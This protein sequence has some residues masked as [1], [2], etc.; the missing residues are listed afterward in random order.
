MGDVSAFA[1]LLDTQKTAFDQK[2]EVGRELARVTEIP[3]VSLHAD[4]AIGNIFVA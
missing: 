3:H 1:V 4:P 2:A